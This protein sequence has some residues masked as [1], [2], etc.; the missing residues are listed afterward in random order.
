VELPPLLGWRAL[1]RTTPL[2]FPIRD[3]RLFHGNLPRLRISTQHHRPPRLPL[4]RTHFASR[5]P[6]FARPRVPR[7][8]HA[9][10]PPHGVVATTIPD[11]AGVD[12]TFR[13]RL[14]ARPVPPALRPQPRHEHLHRDST[15]SPQV[16]R[17]S[18][19]RAAHASHSITPS[20]FA[21][22]G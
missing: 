13:P 12:Q 19:P 7:W 9:G 3:R 5:E 15:R 18:V 1:R 10:R 20:L 16:K 14:I 21:V 8:S 17:S 6:A 4:L 2:P 22:R 11:F